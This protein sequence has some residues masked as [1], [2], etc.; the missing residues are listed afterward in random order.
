MTGV[1]SNKSHAP[2]VSRHYGDLGRD[3]IYRNVTSV[4]PSPLQLNKVPVGQGIF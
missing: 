3:V 4:F 1:Q 2:P